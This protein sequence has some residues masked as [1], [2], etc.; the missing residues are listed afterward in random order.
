MTCSQDTVVEG[1]CEN[2]HIV[3]L[4]FSRVKQFAT[5]EYKVHSENNYKE[6]SQGAINQQN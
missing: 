5:E 6:V 1:K 2:F 3:L 4:S